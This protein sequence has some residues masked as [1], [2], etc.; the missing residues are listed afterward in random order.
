MDPIFSSSS[1]SDSDFYKCSKDSCFQVNYR[2]WK[3]CNTLSLKI[4]YIVG[5]T[6]RFAVSNTSYIIKKAVQ[7]FHL[8]QAAQLFMKTFKWSANKFLKGSSIVINSAIKGIKAIVNSTNSKIKN[9]SNCSG[10]TN[11]NA[12]TKKV[13][14]LFSTVKSLSFKTYNVLKTI[15]NWTIVPL[16]NRVLCPVGRFVFDLLK[17][18]QPYCA[19]GLKGLNKFILIPL[20]QHVLSPLAL[21]LKN[22]AYNIISKGVEFLGKVLPPV[23][24]K[25]IKPLF[26]H[27]LK[28]VFISIF[29]VLDGLAGGLFSNRTK[30]TKDIDLKLEIDSEKDNEDEIVDFAIVKLAQDE[31]LA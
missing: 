18:S 8:D 23:A 19:K 12:K 7:I 4:G 30:K 28:P 25:T 15:S 14:G 24:N 22:L 9:S 29:D 21:K 20:Y 6:I 31:I 27:V 26:N 16:Y 1:S 5:N 2:Q 13:T 11:I 3:D 17:K 10:S